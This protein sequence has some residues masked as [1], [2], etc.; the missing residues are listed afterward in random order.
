MAN[1]PQNSYP[2]VQSYQTTGYGMQP[3]QTAIMPQQAPQAQIRTVYSEAE[4]RA[5]QIPIDGSTCVFVDANNGRIY[6]KRFDYNNGSFPFDIFQRVQPS[7]QPT[8]QYVTLEQF[9]A[10]KS[11]IEGMIHKPIKGGAKSNE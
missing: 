10:W 1:Y 2:Y 8:E 9:Q 7:E 4:A 6:T 3:P 11:E 5:A